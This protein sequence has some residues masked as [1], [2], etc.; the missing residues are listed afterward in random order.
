MTTALERGEG[1]RNI[2]AAL[3]PWERPGTHCTGGWV[4]PQDQ[5]GQV[6]EILPSLG[7]HPWTVQPVASRYTDYA[8]RPTYC[9]G[10]AAN[11]GHLL[12]YCHAIYTVFSVLRST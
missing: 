8:T 10:N 12:P 1:K 5:S 6:Q 7:F 11:F 3:Y 4:D 2:P 9:L